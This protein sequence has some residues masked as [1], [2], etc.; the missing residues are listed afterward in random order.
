MDCVEEVKVMSGRPCDEHKDSQTDSLD[1][2][3]TRCSAFLETHDNNDPH[4]NM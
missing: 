1:G 2:I 3:W 4:L